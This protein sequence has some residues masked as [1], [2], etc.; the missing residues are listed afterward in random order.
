MNK[1]RLKESPLVSVLMA[2]Y[3]SE[4]YIRVAIESVLNSTYRNLE[5]IITDDRSTDNTLEIAREYEILDQRVKVIL[6]NKNYGDYPN[7]NQSA[8]YAKGKY[9]KYVDHDDYIYPYGIEQLVYYMEQ[10]PE[11][12]YGLCSLEQDVERPFPFLLTPQESYERHYFKSSIFHKAPLSSIIKRNVFNAVGGFTEKPLLGDF[13]MWHILSQK[14]T[15]VLMPHGIVWYR[16][17]ENQESKRV[18]TDPMH[19]FKYLLVQEELIKSDNCPLPREKK[20]T[21]LNK[22][23][24]KLAKSILSAFRRHSI[25]KGIELKK[26]SGLRYVD[27]FYFGVFYK[28]Q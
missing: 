19:A 13:E 16:V 17:H 12:E 9:L 4:K 23:N 5:L 26:A 6:N 24:I 15:V 3:N 27:I 25:K 2:A 8:K 20:S 7:R 28:W 1:M 11:A 22:V 21:I 10:F 14:Y 18:G